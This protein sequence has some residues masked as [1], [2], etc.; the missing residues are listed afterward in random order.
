[1]NALNAAAKVLGESG[2]PDERQ[3]DD[4]RDGQKGV[5]DQPRGGDAARDLVRRNLAGDHGGDGGVVH[6]CCHWLDGKPIVSEYSFR[7]V[8]LVVK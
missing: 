6:E 5:L 8:T 3:G 1:M 4:R 2:T 7:S